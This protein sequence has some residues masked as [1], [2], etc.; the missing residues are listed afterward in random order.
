MIEV[1]L[2]VSLP[3][4]V[5]KA[6]SRMLLTTSVLVAPSRS[7]KTTAGAGLK[8]SCVLLRILYVSK[9]RLEVRY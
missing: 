3:S 6:S 7:S 5:I 8:D 9:D 1:P 4:A 2:R